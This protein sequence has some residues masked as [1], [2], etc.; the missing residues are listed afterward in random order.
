MTAGHIK[1]G[2]GASP[3]R[4]GA[5][6]GERVVGYAR[7]STDEQATS[8]LGLAAQRSAI[9]TR[10]PEAEVVEEVA[11]GAKRGRPVLTEALAGMKR[12]DRLVVSRLDRVSRSAAQACELLDRSLREGWA[13][14]VLDMGLDTGTLQGR[15]MAQVASAFAELERGLV[16]ARTVAA[17]DAR[18]P[19]QAER[20]RAIRELLD[21]G[22][23]CAEVAR[24]LGCHRTTVR[25]EAARPRAA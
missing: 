6:G 9:L 23:G 20:R 22:Y 4:A 17:V 11:S 8:G 7:C 12:G 2:R 16:V 18:D 13:L 5:T 15:A 24:R 1:D 14:E 10:H 19:R 25:R 3:A 21:A